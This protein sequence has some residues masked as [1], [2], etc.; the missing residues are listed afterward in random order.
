MAREL[1]DEMITLIR[2]E[3][4]NN[5]APKSCK[6]VKNYGDEPFCDVEVEDLGILI[7]KKTL[8]STKIGS[9]GIICFLNGNLNEGIVITS[10]DSDSNSN[11]NSFDIDNLE[12]DFNLNFGISG[13][14]D[15]ITVETF[16]KQK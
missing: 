12:I 3:S 5:P 13:R 10:S 8:G 2:S 14:D 16:L 7:Y 4:N 6:V 11:N 1:I 9:E 15:I